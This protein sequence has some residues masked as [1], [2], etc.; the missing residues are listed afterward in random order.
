MFNPQA[1]QRSRFQSNLFF[2]EF[3]KKHA[4]VNWSVDVIYGFINDLD[5]FKPPL[6]VKLCL[7]SVS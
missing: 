6:L 7:Y 4:E 5:T 2:N 3:D 1:I